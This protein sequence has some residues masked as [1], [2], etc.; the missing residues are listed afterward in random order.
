MCSTMPNKST[1]TTL[2]STVNRRSAYSVNSRTIVGDTEA[3]HASG[4]M[5]EDGTYVSEEPSNENIGMI[6]G[7][8]DSMDPVWSS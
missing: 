6:V 8:R 7:W 3:Y 5:E 1:Q 2:T 4:A